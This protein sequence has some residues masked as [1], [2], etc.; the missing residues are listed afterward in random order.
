MPQVGHQRVPQKAIA[1][2]ASGLVRRWPCCPLLACG[3]LCRRTRRGDT[4][5]VVKSSVLGITSPTIPRIASHR[6]PSTH[7]CRG[8]AV[9]PPPGPGPKSQISGVR[10]GEAVLR[11]NP[12][13]PCRLPVAVLATECPPHRWVL[14]PLAVV[15]TLENACIR[16]SARWTRAQPSGCAARCWLAGPCAAGRGAEL[17]GRTRAC[18][19]GQWR[20]AQPATHCCSG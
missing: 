6:R 11:R 1:L 7:R 4:E 20:A 17:Q 3:P 9:N 12:P 14:E 13:H 16:G 18:P 10:R 15:E 2:R 8:H 5:G 19:A